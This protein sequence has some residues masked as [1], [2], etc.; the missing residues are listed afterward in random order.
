MSTQIAPTRPDLFDPATIAALGRIEIVARWI[1]DGFISGL[2]R[3]PRKGFSV[4]F[5]EHRPYQLG[6]D[7]R[8]LDWRI[9]ARADRWVVKQFEEETNLRATIV[10]DISRSMNWRGAP[11]RLTKLEYARH[12]TAALA[13]LLI[14]QRDAVGLLT[15]DEVVRTSIS[16]R[17][18]TVQWR[19][20]VGALEHGGEGKKSMAP[21]ALEQAARIVRRPGMVILLSDL[22]MDP[23]E[24]E[25]AIRALRAVGHDV[26]VFHILDPAERNLEGTGE[27]TFIDPETGT[28]M[29]VS[30]TNVREAY[31]T[32]VEAA[33]AEWR[34][35]LASTGARYEVVMTNVPF[36]VPLRRA[37]DARQALP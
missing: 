1:V 8:Y 15:F 25:R 26:N 5:A 3:S 12:L 30:V 6:D 29:P 2:H 20:I 34:T 10:L 23:P 18:R 27:A 37:F 9:A 28:S 14:R 22:L 21:A 13:L 35:S 17:A 31:A 19:R 11:S 33:I 24:V 36:G 7:L 16:P 4:E 32:T